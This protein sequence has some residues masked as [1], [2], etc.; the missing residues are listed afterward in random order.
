MALGGFLWGGAASR[1]TVPVALDL[2]AV[3]LVIGLAVGLRYRLSEAE[4]FESEPLSLMPTP[5]VTGQIKADAGPVMVSIE[6]EIDP[7]RA[8]DFRHAMNALRTIRYRD[9]AVFWGLFSDV[10][11]PGRYI[12]Y[13]MVESWA[14]H[15]RQHSRATDEDAPALERARGFHIRPG[16]PIVSHQIAATG[17]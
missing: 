16:P 4:T 14:E 5:E 1:S 6:Y 11:K 12:E 15:V 8:T 9:G 13:F 3:L 7:A 17:R 2:A 10:A